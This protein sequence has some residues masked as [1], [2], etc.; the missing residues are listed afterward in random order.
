MIRRYVRDNGHGL[1]IH[2]N[3]MVKCVYYIGLRFNGYFV[4]SVALIDS[5]YRMNIISGMGHSRLDSV[6]PLVL[7]TV[8]Q[9]P[10]H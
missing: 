3:F 7:C 10:R 2:V 9:Y 4:A 1:T 6:L 5:H 8:V